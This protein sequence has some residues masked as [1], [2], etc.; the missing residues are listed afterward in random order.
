MRRWHRTLK[1]NALLE[2]ARGQHVPVNI[3][4]RH[5]ENAR[6]LFGVRP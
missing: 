2:A 1:L 6:R 3:L 5:N 4:M